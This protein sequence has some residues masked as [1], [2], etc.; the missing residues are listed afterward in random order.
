MPLKRKDASSPLTPSQHLANAKEILQEI[1]NAIDAL[2][3]KNRKLVEKYVEL[4][5]R[6]VSTDEGAR[7]MNL[8]DTQMAVMYLEE[9]M[10]DHKEPKPTQ[11]LMA[12][13]EIKPQ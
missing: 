9:F 2:P 5:K 13:R 4:I 12:T 11:V 1:Q 7:A 8:V 10:E 3:E 6:I